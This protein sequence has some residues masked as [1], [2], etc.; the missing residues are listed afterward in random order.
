MK[1]GIISPVWVPVPPPGYGG[2]E[3]VVALE[4]ED[5]VSRG[6]DVTLFASGDSVTS[7]NQRAIFD[8]PPDMTLMGDIW[9]DAI[10][11]AFAGMATDEFDIIHDHNG[12]LGAAIA[13][14]ARRTPTVQTLHG[15]W[16]H[17]AR[18]FYDLVSDSIHL[19][20]ISERQRALNPDIRYA[21]VVHNGLDL[22]TFEYKTEKQD[23]L[24]YIGRSAPDKGPAEAIDLARSVDMP[25]KMI[26]R[27][28]RMSAKPEEADEVDYWE[29]E[30]EPR[31][32]SDIEVY[33]FVAHEKK[34]EILANASAFI[35]PLNWEEPFGLTTIE[36]MACGTPVVA[37][38]MGALP[39]VVVDG[40]TGYLRTTPDE[41]TSAL[42]EV[43]AGAIDPAAC[44]ARVETEF[45]G[46]AMGAKYEALFEKI[47]AE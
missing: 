10:H 46:A 9:Y 23:Y 22:E 32:G 7:A 8:T 28:A 37:R 39:E 41:L 21:G 19:V 43:L 5:L 24:A 36:A 44:R 40:E 18:R 26:V 1:I 17:T 33:E 11:A 2:T 27:R 35:F 38:P 20:A 34:V 3:R 29:T 6:H 25:L 12:P 42:R 31:L 15:A 14:C 16:S 13:A 4:V 47:L 30:I 45:S